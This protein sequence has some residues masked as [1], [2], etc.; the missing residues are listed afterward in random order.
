MEACQQHAHSN[1]LLQSQD[2]AGVTTQTHVQQVCIGQNMHNVAGSISAAA[3]MC[4]TVSAQRTTGVHTCAIPC[5]KHVPKDRKASRALV[6]KQYVQWASMQDAD[7]A[8]RWSVACS[9]SVLV[10]AKIRRCSICGLLFSQDFIH[11]CGHES[12][13][14]FDETKCKLT[15][16][17]L[18]PC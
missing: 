2:K 8:S 16:W 5:M 11:L 7:R 3:D 17:Y 10:L 14:I 12:H 15:S 18:E 6:L 13:C 1:S 4:N 9:L